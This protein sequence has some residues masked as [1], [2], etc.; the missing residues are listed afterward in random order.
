MTKFLTALVAMLFVFASA[1]AETVSASGTKVWGDPTKGL[2]CWSG[3]APDRIDEYDAAASNRALGAVVQS[4]CTQ[5]G[6][7]NRFN[8]ITGGRWWMIDKAGSD[9]LQLGAGVCRACDNG[10]GCALKLT[11]DP[12]R[13]TSCLANVAFT[14]AVVNANS[15]SL[16]VRAAWNMGA[17]PPPAAS[18]P[19]AS[20]AQQARP[21]YEW[22]L[23]PTNVHE[24]QKWT[25]MQW[26]GKQWVSAP[27]PR[28]SG[29]KSAVKAAPAKDDCVPGK[30]IET[31][32]GTIQCINKLLVRIGDA[33]EPVGAT[34]PAAPAASA[35]A[36]PAAATPAAPAAGAKKQG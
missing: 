3:L 9:G 1:H 4:G 7:Q 35:P 10:A 14:G 24:N 2:V 26:D 21:G 6:G 28:K 13:D 29:M 31:K 12:A 16:D 18:A 36:A 17:A 8:F 30:P 20:T 34:A 25:S 19:A 23:V 22:K 33:P 11:A 5:L 27:E 32:D 15:I